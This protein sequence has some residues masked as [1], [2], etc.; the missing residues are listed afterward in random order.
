MKPGSN[1]S[2]WVGEL[3]RLFN[4]MDVADD[5][6]AVVAMQGAAALLREHDLSFRQLVQRM[7]AQHLLMPLKIATAIQIMDSD[8][9]SE[10]ESALLGAR[11]M[12]RSC[13][14]TFGQIVTALHVQRADADEVIRLRQAFALETQRVQALQ[15]EVERLQ[16]ERSSSKRDYTRVPA[17]MIALSSFAFCCIGLA[18]FAVW[19]F[20]QAL[21]PG[22]ADARG[23]TASAVGPA[24]PGLSMV[25]PAAPFTVPVPSV[26]VKAQPSQN[27]PRE[28]QRQCWRDRSIEGQCF[29]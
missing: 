25:H 5:A 2:G 17:G 1:T 8:L 20:A 14:L 4:G 29:Q 10:S 26:V 12:M 24:G 18:A 15:V 27:S 23:I 21:E 7:E 6:A 3:N 19:T 9:L 22:K 11:R 13:G 16:L 28:K